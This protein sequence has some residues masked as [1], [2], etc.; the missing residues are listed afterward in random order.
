[1]TRI[2]SFGS[3][4][5][6]VAVAML[7]AFVISPSGPPVAFAYG[8]VASIAGFGVCVIAEQASKPP[9]TRYVAVPASD[10][11][12]RKASRIRYEPRRC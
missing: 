1:M 4:L 7:A 12:Y 10:S 6:I 8:G 2:R 9:S 11:M 5:L 3:F